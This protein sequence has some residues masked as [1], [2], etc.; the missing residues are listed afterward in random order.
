MAE[1][2]P[3]EMSDNMNAKISDNWMDL[4]EKDGHIYLKQCVWI[5]VKNLTLWVTIITLLKL[6]TYPLSVIA[7][8]R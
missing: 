7:F 4:I 5:F 6:S 8:I 3:C 2:H 1:G